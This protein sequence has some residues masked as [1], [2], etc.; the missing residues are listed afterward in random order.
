MYPTRLNLLSPEK[1]RHLER[2]AIFQFLRN[3]S[4][5]FFVVVSVSAVAV[6][7]SQYVLERFFHDITNNVSSVASY[8]AN[9]NRDIR[10]VNEIL[11][12]AA[13]IQQEY[14][15]WTPLMAEI[16]GAI[17]P[18]VKLTAL[19][20]KPVSGE[21]NLAGVAATR[22]DLIA[23][24]KLLEEISCSGRCRLA[25]PLSPGQLTHKENVSFSLT[26]A[27]KPL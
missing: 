9:I 13:Q 26:A 22:E 21:I 19:Q 11:K 7:G 25:A 4:E 2:L 3:L 20:I 15:E 8:Y 17:P 1:K 16:A 5:V 24:S 10:D 6:M 18:G 27:M 12:D 23:L 14:R